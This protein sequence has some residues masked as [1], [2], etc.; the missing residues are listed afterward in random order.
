MA[1]KILT[2]AYTQG[3]GKKE[4]G[5]KKIHTKWLNTDPVPCSK[6]IIWLDV[7]TSS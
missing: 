2:L 5:R 6:C 4:K 3:W 7:G 1:K